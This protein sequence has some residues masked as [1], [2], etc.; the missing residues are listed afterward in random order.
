MDQSIQQQ[1]PLLLD[2]MR[3]AA[4]D[5]FQRVQS[6]RQLSE[7]K[8]DGSLLTATDIALQES[9]SKILSSHFPD[10]PVL[11]E[12]MTEDEQAAILATGCCWLLDPLDGTSNF[13]HGIPVYS[14]SLA[15]MQQG[16][17]VAGMVYDPNRDE[18]FHALK[19]QGAYLNQQP[20]CRRDDKPC[21]LRHAMSII[22]T[23]RLP[24][25]LAIAIAT[26]NP[27]HSQRSFGSVALDWCWL[28]AG[29][30]QTYL[31]GRQKLWDF[32]A[33]ALVA[34]EA[35]CL[36]VTMQDAHI[37]SSPLTLTARS[38]VGACPSLATIWPEW[39]RKHN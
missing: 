20:L 15:L 31:H 37:L 11:G 21:E 2:S 30:I 23:K 33:G 36:T 18:C 24:T 22:D 39:I 35:G 27:Y 25:D 6:G 5:I 13:S 10:I 17:V 32:A 7:R 3:E 4:R 16:E 28:A 19:G 1:W 38:A 12:E 26:E 9:I 8:S 34:Q 29:R 14:V